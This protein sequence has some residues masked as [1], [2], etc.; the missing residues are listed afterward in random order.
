[1]STETRTTCPYCGVGC[2]VLA[3][4]GKPVAGDPDHP[5]NFGR[6]CS[7]GSAL[8]ETLSPDGRLLHPE[9]NGVR[10]D[11]N[12]AL[13]AVADGFAKTIAAHGPDS[14]ALYVSGQLLTED[15]YAANKL[16][17]GFLGT[18]NIDS[19]SRL[20]MASAVAGHRRAFG[21]DVVPGIYEDLE[22][23]DLVVLVGSNTAWCHP[24]LYQRILAAREM[25]PQ[26]RII[27]IDPRRTAT[28]EGADLHLPLAPGTDVALFTGLLAHLASHGALDEEYVSNATTG[29]ADALATARAQTPD[30]AA[31]AALC[32]LEPAAAETFY[33]WFAAT[34]R[35]V[36]VFSQGVNQSSAGTD[37]VNA[38]LNVHLATGRIGR[39]GMGPFSVT[40]QPNAM[41]GRE[42]GALANT[43]AAH[44][45][46]DRPGDT[47]L[48]RDYWGA[49]NLAAA[50]GLKAVD[51]FRGIDAGRIKAVWIM[52]TNPV[53]S[54]PEAA[55]IRRALQNC[56]LVVVSDCMREADTAD[57]ADIRLPALGWGEKDGTVTN[58][59]RMIS[60]QRAFLPAPGEARPDWWIIAQVAQ[61]LG[62]ASA[63]DWNGPAG[64]FREHAALSGL[65]NGGQRVFDISSLA[66]LTDAEYDTMAPTRWPC[67]AQAPASGASATDASGRLFGAG[68][69][70]APG[71][72]ARLIATPHRRPARATS[73]EYPLVL[74]TGRVRDQWH[75]MTRT[76]K[77]A[78]LMAH[79][80]E[81]F[82]AIHPDDAAGLPDGALAAIE[83]ST[84]RAVLRLRHDAGL[85]CGNVFAP[86]HW[87]A[88]FAPSGRINPAVNAETD[89]I[90]GQPELKHT[91]V[92]L[93]PF[94]AAWHGF[95]I[96]RRDLG[97]ALADWTA[98]LPATDNVWR[99]E[100]AGTEA[101]E[102][103][104]GRL[105]ALFG[106][107]P[108]MA[109]SDP[110]QK[111]YRA[112]LLL[113][114]RLEACLFIG[115]DHQLPA[116]DWLVSRFALDALAPGERR[117]LLAAR[118]ADG[119]LPEPP[120]CVCHGVGA[121]QIGQAIA[122]GHASVEAI[123][124]AT[125]AGTNCGSCR[126]EIR[127]LL[128]ASNILLEPV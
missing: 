89:P 17:K 45:E 33:G 104:F 79:T 65:G 74:L 67:P 88:R 57:Y 12:D 110:A 101:P 117:C 63:F 99:H 10:A 103:A 83:A 60:R 114:G 71:G 6:L 70:P 78:R 87:T 105:R 31:A 7:K 118:P 121:N 80:P 44:L 94:A 56:P 27:V 124:R 126:P 46:W 47:D 8:A 37:K 64:I 16:A 48:L 30:S 112:A 82:L 15:Y 24:V 95:L 43:L 36:T 53:V 113:D 58:S 32:G 9:I 51:L 122:A 128:Q 73:A 86:M 25:R 93:V 54:L 125:K 61:R 76:G 52:A 23:A 68:G 127:A 42:V 111:I 35:V 66:T 115:P 106:E 85:R 75:T 19:N 81:P 28:C 18:A 69:F 26:M 50:P 116:R 92:R 55:S 4:A 59:E 34:G 90:S 91:P 77:A 1:M 13:A 123:G 2:G 62:H 109:L 21:E 5:A 29:L 41:G 38:I 49:P 102:A 14:V 20:C 96:S 39:P 100:L 97:T 120:V 3:Q 72:R 40:G 98:V 107:A 108:W 84:G 11:W 119:K 22:L